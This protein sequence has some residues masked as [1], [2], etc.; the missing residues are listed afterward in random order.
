MKWNRVKVYIFKQDRLRFFLFASLFLQD[1]WA[2]KYLW[3]SE[4]KEKI[5]N[6]V[7]ERMKRAKQTNLQ[8]IFLSKMHLGCGNH[9]TK[10]S[11]ELNM[12]KI[13]FYVFHPT[14]FFFVYTF[15]VGWIKRERER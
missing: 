12:T 6:S 10:A 9:L 2:I 8:Q 3:S 5:Y 13:D 11:V 4:K 15:Y 14:I 7:G 1:L